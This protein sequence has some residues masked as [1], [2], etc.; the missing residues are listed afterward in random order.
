MMWE[1]ERGRFAREHLSQ[2]SY[3]PGSKSAP[4][5]FISNVYQKPSEGKYSTGF[6]V[7]G[8]IADFKIKVC[9]KRTAILSFAP[10]IL[11]CGQN[12]TE[13]WVFKKLLLE[14]KG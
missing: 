11:I 4:S 5:R 10:H 8:L 1:E 12:Q 3:Q 2:M 13:K 7:S 14:E 6:W 9:V